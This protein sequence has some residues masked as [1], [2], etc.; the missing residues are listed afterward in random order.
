[1][2]KTNS[3]MPIEVL[4]PGKAPKMPT[5]ETRGRPELYPFADLAVGG[6][7]KVAPEKVVSVRQLVNKRNRKAG[8]GP[9]FKLGVAEDGFYYVWRLS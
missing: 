8:D 3:E 6:A 7:F 5:E 1:M 2:T 9:T 4:E